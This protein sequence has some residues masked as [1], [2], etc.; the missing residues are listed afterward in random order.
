MKDNNQPPRF[1]PYAFISNSMNMIALKAR[2]I[3]RNNDLKLHNILNINED[4]DEDNLR[5][6]EGKEDQ[7][8]NKTQHLSR[9]LKGRYRRNQLNELKEKSIKEIIKDEE[10][11]V[12]LVAQTKAIV[13]RKFYHSHCIPLTKRKGSLP[14]LSNN[15]TRLHDAPESKSSLSCMPT[16]RKISDNAFNSKQ[17]HCSDMRLGNAKDNHAEFALKPQRNSLACINETTSRKIPVMKRNNRISPYEALNQEGTLYHSLFNANKRVMKYGV[18]NLLSLRPSLD[19]QNKVNCFV[20]NYNKSQSLNE[21]RL[22]SMRSINDHFK[23]DNNYDNDNE[24]KPLYVNIPLTTR[25][26]IIFKGIIHE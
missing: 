4:N 16:R 7:L 5:E 6:E 2:L 11:K 12:Y 10:H 3:L 1:H 15:K 20:M 21:D 13:D 19:L 17:P 14:V 24:N 23:N 8:I 22:S 25:N 26:P 9:A 18:W